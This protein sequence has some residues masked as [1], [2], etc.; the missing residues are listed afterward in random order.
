MASSLHKGWGFSVSGRGLFSQCRKIGAYY[1]YIYI[2]KDGKGA[3][4]VILQA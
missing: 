1:A 2:Y 4:M 3:M